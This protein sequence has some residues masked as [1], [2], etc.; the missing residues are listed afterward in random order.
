MWRDV[1]RSAAALGGALRLPYPSTGDRIVPLPEPIHVLRGC[2]RCGTF[3]CFSIC[4]CYNR[5]NRLERGVEGC[6]AFSLHSGSSLRQNLA[7]GRYA[8]VPVGHG[9]GPENIPLRK[10]ERRPNFLMRDFLW[11]SLAHTEQQDGKRQ[12]ALGDAHGDTLPEANIQQELGKVNGTCQD[13][14]RKGVAKYSGGDQA[15]RAM[16]TAMQS[17]PDAF[18]RRTSRAAGL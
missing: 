12:E 3:L 17:E 6:I 18:R 1:G 9:R 16:R 7:R 2:K 5:L 15:A 8:T 13:R 10:G 11:I 4:C 14:G